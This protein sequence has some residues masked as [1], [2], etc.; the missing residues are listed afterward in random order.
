MELGTHSEEWIRL[1]ETLLL[2][3]KPTS[4]QTNS[5]LPDVDTWLYHQRPP[6]PFPW[7]RPRAEPPEALEKG[8][9]GL[10]PFFLFFL[11]PEEREAWEPGFCCRGTTGETPPAWAPEV[12][13]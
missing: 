6:F 5:P 10:F 13:G 7:P 2:F 11:P 3:A 9:P 12:P 1:P 8:P 4:G